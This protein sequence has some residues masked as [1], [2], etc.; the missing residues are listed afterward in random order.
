MNFLAH[1]FLADSHPESILGNLMADFLK[2][3]EAEELPEGIRE[4]VCLHRQVDAFTDAHPVFR[5]STHR[6]RRRWGRYSGI[7]IDMFYDHFLAANW[8]QYAD[9][10]LRNFADRVYEVLRD[11]DEHLPERMQKAAR[12]MIQYDWLVSYA[13]LEKLE[14]SLNRL[15]RRSRNPDLRLDHAMRDLNA[16]YSDLQM[17]FRSFFPALVEFA[18]RAKREPA[19]L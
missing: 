4:G 2:G 19:D 1:A 10:P 3:R 13:D 14:V 11:H 15:S 16:L 7:L 9:Q 17:D 6:I 12:R 18:E 5:R 8:D